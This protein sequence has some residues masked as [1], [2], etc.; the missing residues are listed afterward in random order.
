VVQEAVRRLGFERL[1]RKVTRCAERLDEIVR[2]RTVVLC[3]A[4]LV[5]LRGTLAPPGGAPSVR[6][7]SDPAAWDQLIYEGVFEALGYAKNKCGCAA[8][9]RSVPLSLLRRIGLSKGEEV[10]GVLFGAAGLLPSPRRLPDAASRAKV[11]SMRRYWR[12]HRP[13]IR[14]PLLHESDWLFFRLRPSNFPTARI[15]VLS[16]LLPRL[17]SSGGLSAL[18][19]AVRYP[20]PTERWRAVR[21]LFAIQPEPYWAEHLHFAGL[22]GPPGARLGT[23]RIAEITV[24]ILVPVLLLAARLFRETDLERRSWE[25]LDAVPPPPNRMTR[26]FPGGSG[27]RPSRVSA[28]IQQGILEWTA[29][30]SHPVRCAG[31]PLD[32]AGHSIKT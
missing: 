25:L 14:G 31:C 21:Q 32:A 29:M 15:A 11:R 27:S 17:F 30:H 23:G 20:S 2:N 7:R 9:A 4:G 24:N 5:Y 19:N 18:V 12:A 3:E 13:E 16:Y 6:E 1:N 22:P 8:L 10:Q 28:L 26:E